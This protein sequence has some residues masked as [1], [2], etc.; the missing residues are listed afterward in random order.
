MTIASLS[1]VRENIAPPLAFIFNACVLTNCDYMTLVY[2][3]FTNVL[4]RYSYLTRRSSALAHTQAERWECEWNFR[5]HPVV[6]R[7]QIRPSFVDGKFSLAQADC[8]F[9]FIHYTRVFCADRAARTIR[10]RQCSGRN[11]WLSY[12]REVSLLSPCST[13]AFFLLT[14]LIGSRSSMRLPRLI[15]PSET[16]E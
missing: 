6:I 1:S 11:E 12:R 15:Y 3:Y 9:I 4:Y 14:D 8:W 2:I 16:G 10:R 5:F 7:V 13:K